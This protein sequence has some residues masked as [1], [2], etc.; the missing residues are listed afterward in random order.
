MAN[1]TYATV[2]SKIKPLLGKVN[3]VGIPA[4]INKAWLKSLGFK[5][6]NDVALIGVLKFIGFI[7]SNNVPTQAWKEYRGSKHKRV[8]GNAIREGY[9]DLYAVYPDAHKR[10]NEEIDHVFSTNSSAGKQVISKAISTFRALVEEAEFSAAKGQSAPEEKPVQKGEPV[11]QTPPSFEQGMSDPSL[12]IDVQIHISPEATA[13]QI[14]Q[15]F[16]SMAKH[17]YASKKNK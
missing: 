17:L 8:L 4:K 10:T 2:V 6:S 12:H 5:S 3:E 9:S 1:F 16:A 11:V 7:D 13:D 15:V 14:D